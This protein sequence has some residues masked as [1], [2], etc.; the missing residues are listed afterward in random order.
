ML[1]LTIMLDLMLMWKSL[2]LLTTDARAAH[3]VQV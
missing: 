1:K 3:G 2:L